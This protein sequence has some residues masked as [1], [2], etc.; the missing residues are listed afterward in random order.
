MPAV[1]SLSCAPRI[2]LDGLRRLGDHHSA[3][4]KHGELPRFL[5]GNKAHTDQLGL[6]ALN[7][8]RIRGSCNLFIDKVFE[9]VGL[10]KDWGRPLKLC[11]LQKHIALKPNQILICGDLGLSADHPNRCV[12]GPGVEQYRARQGGTAIAKL[13]KSGRSHL[14]LGIAP[15]ARSM[16]HR[17]PHD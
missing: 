2:P 12:L 14:L 9:S 8:N 7:T 3:V 6:P 1:A 11:S 5:V 13:F 4:G 10:N 16:Y 17:L 15:R